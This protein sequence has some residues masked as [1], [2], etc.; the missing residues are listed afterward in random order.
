MPDGYRKRTGE[1]ARPGGFP[2]GYTGPRELPERW[3]AQALMSMAVPS[4][5][6]DYGHSLVSTVRNIPGLMRESKQALY[7]ESSPEYLLGMSELAAMTLG[8]G[9]KG[10]LPAGATGVGQIR[11]IKPIKPIKPVHGTTLDRL[12]GILTK[13][14]DKGSALD[15]TKGKS[16]A[17]D[18]EVMV[19]VPTARTGEYIAHN[20]FFKSANIAKPTKVTIDLDFLSDAGAEEALEQIAKLKGKHP[21]IKWK[22]KGEPPGA[23]AVT[24]ANVAKLY[25]R[26]YDLTPKDALE[27]AKVD[28]ETDVMGMYRRDTKKYV[29]TIEEYKNMLKYWEEIGK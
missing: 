23:D 4:V 20:K 19:E 29:D 8:G 11:G 6:K 13:G 3:K 15:L 27:I 28:F 1:V 9:W 5:L 12:D 21:G 22:I 16:W 26:E 10:G 2:K 25:E 17:S 7:K 18:Y 14:L 24:V